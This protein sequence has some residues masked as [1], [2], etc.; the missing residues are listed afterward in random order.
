M[1]LRH[2][3][4]AVAALPRYSF[5]INEPQK[6]KG[7]W[8]EY[9]SKKR[10]LSLELGCGFGRFSAEYCTL[11]PNQNLIAVDRSRDV[12]VGA[13]RLIHETSRDEH[14]NLL[15]CDM[16]AYNIENCLDETD[17]VENIFIF[18]CNP[19]PKRSHHRRRLTYPALLERYKKLMKS[20]AH[21]FFK[22]DDEGLY[23]ASLRYFEECG[24]ELLYNSENLSDDHQYEPLKIKTE[25]EQKFRSLGQNIYAAVVRVE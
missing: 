15:V 11:Y 21:I 4:K 1:R 22:T 17:G 18:F 12:L 6:L 8:Q 2:K 13:C 20:G 9:F 3:P 10:P 19:W 16:D 23:R 7:I 5:Y 25:Y 14:G 24:L